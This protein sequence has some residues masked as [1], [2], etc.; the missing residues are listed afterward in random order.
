[1]ASHA[2][3]SQTLGSV[4]G[5]SDVLVALAIIGASK[6]VTDSDDPEFSEVEAFALF[7]RMVM[8]LTGQVQISGIR[9][10][11]RSFPWLHRR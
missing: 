1:M 10:Y 9:L 6:T 2:G 7:D 11:H 8:Y 3:T 5:V 4:I